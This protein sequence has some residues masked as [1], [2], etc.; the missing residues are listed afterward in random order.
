MKILTAKTGLCLLIVWA[1]LMPACRARKKPVFEPSLEEA[2]TF[3]A[4]GEYERAIDAYQAAAK[5][6]PGERA[7]LA[8]YVMALEGMGSRADRI[9]AAGDFKTAE[10]IY[11]L[12]LNAYPRFKELQLPLSFAQP[13]LNRKIRESRFGRAEM[14]ARRAFESGDFQ[15]ALEAYGNFAPADFEAANQVD[16]F[17]KIIEEVKQQADSAVAA[18]DFVRAGKAYAALI[19]SY[20]RLQELDLPLAL[21]QSQLEEGLENCRTMLTRKGLEEYR[22][23]NLALAIAQ[24]EELLEFDPDNAEIRKAVET[25]IDQQ[26]KLRKK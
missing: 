26:K 14:E 7:V 18:G 16:R 4:S 23:G 5:T 25:A 2:R 6:F 3:V 15:K 9:L 10:R 24:W 12:L 8:D 19:K 13:W 22:K 17:K 21:L 1:C 20:P 11:V